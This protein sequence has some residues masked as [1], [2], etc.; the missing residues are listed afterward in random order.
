M[1]AIATDCNQS[2]DALTISFVSFFEPLSLKALSG[3]L[4]SMKKGWVEVMGASG[5]VVVA[6]VV[7]DY[8]IVVFE[9][10]FA[11]NCAWA[12]Y[13][14]WHSSTKF[15]FPLF[16]FFFADTKQLKIVRC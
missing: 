11:L 10:F 3:S 2:R 5:V 15:N 4:E 16:F 12:C 13:C 1:R 9:G 6:S 7:S 14:P 8:R